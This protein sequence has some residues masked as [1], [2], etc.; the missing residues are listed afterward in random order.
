MFKRFID[1]LARME[2][3]WT[4]AT[5]SDVEILASEL[6]ELREKVRTLEAKD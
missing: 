4:A 1:W 2:A 6:T 5:R 3:A